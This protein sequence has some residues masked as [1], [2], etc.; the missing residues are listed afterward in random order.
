MGISAKQKED[1]GR[2]RYI[3]ALERFTRSVMGYLAKEEETDFEGFT[4]RVGKQYELL[5]KA[6]KTPLYKAEYVQQEAF[7][8]QIL[9]AARAECEEFDAL[10]QK[11]L[12]ASNQLH[13]NRNSKKYKKEKHTKQS[14]NDGY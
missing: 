3:R 11:L 12:Y 1:I 13:K 14:Y 9:A 6:E 8:D 5:K 7:V 4:A 2:L 10:R